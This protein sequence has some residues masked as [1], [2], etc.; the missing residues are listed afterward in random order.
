MLENA[1]ATCSGS[2]L[3]LFS[4]NCPAFSALFPQRPKINIRVSESR[5]NAAREAV[6]LWKKK[7]I[8]ETRSIRY[9]EYVIP[10]PQ[11]S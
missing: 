8:I 1:S 6:P 2:T 4:G 3:G 7:P 9:A 11:G 5:F 10:I